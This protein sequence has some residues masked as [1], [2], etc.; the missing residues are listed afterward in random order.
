VKAKHDFHPIASTRIKWIKT[1]R[2]VEKA[3]PNE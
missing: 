1:S 2:E 3:M